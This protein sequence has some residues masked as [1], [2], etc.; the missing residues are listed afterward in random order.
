MCE[1]GRNYNHFVCGDA[2]RK[3]LF[4][5]AFGVK[6]DGS[7]A[8]EFEETTRAKVTTKLVVL[9]GLGHC[10]AQIDDLDEVG[11]KEH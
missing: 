4:P 5:L 3:H 8:L 7:E 2:A 11:L 10:G 1:A 9:A 6:E